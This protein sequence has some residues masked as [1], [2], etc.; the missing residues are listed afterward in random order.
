MRALAI[1][2]HSLIDAVTD[3]VADVRALYGEKAFDAKVDLNDVELTLPHISLREKLP[4]L[5]PDTRIDPGNCLAQ[6]A[7]VAVV[8]YSN[9]SEKFRA[10]TEKVLKNLAIAPAL[11]LIFRHSGE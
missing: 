6:A 8:L 5:F 3:D 9:R 7:D 10:S 2:E 1:N 4:M 11:V